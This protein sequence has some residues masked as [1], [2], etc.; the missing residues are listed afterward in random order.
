[1]QLEETPY[2]WVNDETQTDGD[3][4]VHGAGELRWPHLRVGAPV[5]VRRVGSQAA[6]IGSVTNCVFLSPQMSLPVVLR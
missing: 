4:W 5:V 2:H 3:A 1:M 6:F